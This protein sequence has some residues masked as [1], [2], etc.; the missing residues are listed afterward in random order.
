MIIYFEKNIKT[1]E[2]LEFSF[3]KKSDNLH[4]LGYDYK[5]ENNILKIWIEDDF[6]KYYLFDEREK[7]ILG[8]HLRIF[9]DN[10][11]DIIRK[12]KLKKLKKIKS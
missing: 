11:K 4:F 9:L 10:K 6:E 7:S 12:F 1:G 8:K 3:I 5:L 2:Y